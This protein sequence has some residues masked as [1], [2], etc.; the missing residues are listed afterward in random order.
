[1]K[2]ERLRRYLEILE[3]VG[4]GTNGRNWDALD[5]LSD[6]ELFDDVKVK[7]CL[8][9]T[10]KNGEQP[11]EKQK[12]PIGARKSKYSYIDDEVLFHRLDEIDGEFQDFHISGYKSSLLT[13]ERDEMM[14]ELRSRGYNL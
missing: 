3:D 2:P 8:Q 4:Y 13:K 1:M 6:E 9:I 11:E 7:E 5:R 10:E 14:T 12:M